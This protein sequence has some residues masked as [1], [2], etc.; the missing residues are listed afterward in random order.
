MTG[1]NS[2]AVQ[3]F[4]LKNAGSFVPVVRREDGCAVTFYGG[5]Q[6][7]FKTRVGR[8]SGC[9]A[10]AAADIF[11]YLALQ[12][13]AMKSLFENDSPEIS[14]D[15]FLAHMDAVI[16]FVAPLSIPGTDI[17]YGGLTS[18][19]KFARNCEEYASSRGIIAK[20]SFFSG[21]DT[22]FER[23]VE[24]VSEQLSRDN[25]VALLIMQN[26]KM[27]KIQYTDAYG[28]PAESDMRFHWVAITALR[29][30]P[31]KATIEVSSEGGRATLDFGDVWIGRESVL[32]VHG[33]AY[34]ELP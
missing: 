17:P 3:L 14:V 18:L 31:D 29:K 33:I 21:A 26:R 34:L 5:D 12:N 9:G 27:K 28:R 25:P 4:Q 32:G 2:Q 6:A 15:A 23:T 19:P 11:A 8:Y 7:W 20:C 13:P 1:E 24:I 22:G 16:K 10:V 30:T